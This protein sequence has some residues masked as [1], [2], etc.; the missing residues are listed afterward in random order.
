MICFEHKVV[1]Y[2][3]VKCIKNLLQID[4]P[5][6]KFSARRRSEGGIISRAT[7]GVWIIL[8]LVQNDPEKQNKKQKQNKKYH[9]Q[10]PRAARASPKIAVP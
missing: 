9:E 4:V 2:F 8:I 7:G 10:C 3:H 1:Q 5:G 6:A